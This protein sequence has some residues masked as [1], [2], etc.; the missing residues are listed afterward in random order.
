MPLKKTHWKHLAK[1]G[2]SSKLPPYLKVQS[3]STIIQVLI[4]L[5]H[6]ERVIFNL[7]CF[8]KLI[9]SR[10]LAPEILVTRNLEMYQLRRHKR[11]CTK[12][13]LKSCTLRTEFV[14]SPLTIWVILI[15]FMWDYYTYPVSTDDRLKLK[16]VDL[17]HVEQNDFFQ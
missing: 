14:L 13:Q 12:R 1:R 10:G 15:Q 8:I 17:V 3:L 9:F 4:Y 2:T 5:V 16:N 6:Y 7:L 11:M